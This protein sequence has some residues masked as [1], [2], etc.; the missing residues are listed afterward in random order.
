[1]EVIRGEHLCIGFYAICS[2]TA[3]SLRAPIL[4]PACYAR[5]PPIPPSC[6]INL[7]L[8]TLGMGYRS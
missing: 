1:M 7:V 4:T 5:Q 6:Q 8:I 3:V 2:A